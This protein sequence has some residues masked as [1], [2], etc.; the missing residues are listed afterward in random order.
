MSNGGMAKNAAIVGLMTFI[1][2]V[3]GLFRDILMAHFFGTGVVKSAFDVAYRFPNLFRRLFGEG[4]LS[5][6]L[7]PIYTETMRTEGRR[8]A[9]RLASAVCGITMGILGAAVAVAFLASYAIPSL[10]DVGDKWLE[11]MP[12][13]R[14]MLPYAPL[15][16]L[17]ALIMGILNSLKSFAVPALAPAFQNLCCI[18]VL[19]LVC[20]FLP[21]EGPARIKAVS[22]SILLSGIVQVAVQLP[23]LRRHGVPLSL[24]VPRPLPA[25]AKRVFALT[26]PMAVSAGVIQINVFLD[27][28]LAMKAGEWGPSALG[29]ADRLVYLPLAVCGTAFSIVL[30]PALSEFVTRGDGKSFAGD[31]ARTLR[32]V[33]LVLTPSSL[34]MIVL[35]YPAIAAVYRT[36]AFDDISVRR[37]ATAL[38]A[39]S[40]GL[41]QAGLHK[42]AVTPFYARKDTRTPVIV[43]TAGVA[44]NLLMNLF[45]IWVLPPSLKPIGIAI[46]TSISSTLS[47]AALL[48]ILS[49]SDF[50]GV[51]IFS[52]ASFA[53]DAGSAIAASVAMAIPCHAAYVRVAGAFANPGSKLATFAALAVA[54]PLGAA[55]YFGAMRLIAPAAL[56]DL[57]S[58][59]ASRRARRRGGR[60][61]PTT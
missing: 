41:V 19:A 20:P 27:G 38:V 4:A 17:A 31:F 33:T 51:R 40:A 6:G 44:L 7:I 22:W 26:A 45:F 12:L 15:I 5:A 2:R 54:I 57:V 55:V 34:G 3:G 36:G 14:I 49:R 46:A 13:L 59:F 10:F 29:Y 9:D 28:V 35:A 37:T 8:E 1:S 53:R 25:G 21:A 50:A 42:V 43:G 48:A 60:P 58:E 18:A 52:P 23:V 30:L 32:N 47:A 11:V 56:R 24:A 61:A 39:Y 16:C